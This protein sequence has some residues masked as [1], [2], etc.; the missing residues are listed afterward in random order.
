MFL[1]FLTVYFFFF[2][3]Q[4]KWDYTTDNSFKVGMASVATKY[5]NFNST[6][7]ALKITGQGR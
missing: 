5:C 2:L 4:F 1:D 3:Y 7:C 6:S